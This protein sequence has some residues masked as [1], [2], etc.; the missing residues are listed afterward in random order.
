MFRSNSIKPLPV[1]FFWSG[2]LEWGVQGGRWG[3]TFP[4]QFAPFSHVWLFHIHVFLLFILLS[5][6]LSGCLKSHS[7]L[8]GM[9]ICKDQLS[10]SDREEWDELRMVLV[11]WEL[12]MVLGVVDHEEK[13]PVNP[14][15]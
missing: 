1:V 6:A 10:I 9:N 12:S 3:K 8:T 13:G 4:S 11:R 14:D 5:T 15:F 7:F 2:G